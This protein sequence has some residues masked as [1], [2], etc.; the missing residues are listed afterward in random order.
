[1]LGGR[2]S[3]VDVPAQPHIRTSSNPRFIATVYLSRMSIL[4][5]L[6]LQEPINALCP[7]K[8]NQKSR[9][10]NMVVYKG[11]P[12]LVR[13]TWSGVTTPTP[14]WEQAFSDDGGR[15]WET[16]WVMEFAPAGDGT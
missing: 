8:P 10:A 4:L 6:L 12:I 3:E 2:T 9:A 7:I 15:G 11:R 16:N 5:A 14:R 1:M 13:F